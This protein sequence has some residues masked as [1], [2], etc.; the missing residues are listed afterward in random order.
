MGDGG[1]DAQSTTDREAEQQRAEDCGRGEYEASAPGR[2]DSLEVHAESE[3]D[4]GSL[5]Q[6]LRRLR[7]AAALKWLADSQRQRQTER[8]RDGRR[9][10]RR[11]TENDERDE[12]RDAERLVQ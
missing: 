11:E 1:V 7:R 9:C 2:H 12:D 6:Q 5:K 3:G 10:P 8:Q 4:D